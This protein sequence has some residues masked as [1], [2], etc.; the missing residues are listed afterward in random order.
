MRRKVELPA[1]DEIAFEQAPQHPPAPQDTGGLNVGRPY[2]KRR[3]RLA[4][5][6]L[7]LVVVAVGTV[8][9]E[10][11]LEWQA[12]KQGADLRV[13]LVGY[14][15]MDPESCGSEDERVLSVFKWAKDNGAYIHPNVSLGFFS[16]ASLPGAPPDTPDITIRGLRA[17]GD[18][19]QGHALFAV[20]ETL[21]LHVRRLA[22]HHMLGDIYKRVPQLH[23]DIGGLAVLL[24]TEALN[25][26]SHLRPYLC[27]LPEHVPLPVFYSKER[28][29]QTR[30]ALPEAQRAKFDVLVQA[31]RDVIELHYIYLMPV[32]YRDYP[33][34]FKPS[35]YSY[36]RFAWAVSLV[37]SRTWGRRIPAGRKKNFSG[38][39]S[40]FSHIEC[41]L[42]WVSLVMSRTLGCRIPADKMCSGAQNV[43]S[44]SFPSSI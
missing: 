32:L 11:E 26:S 22:T 3:R 35:E 31:R 17:T 8:T 40:L 5:A 27:S 42:F 12:R 21:L 44:F 7:V 30:G 16:L 23:D 25:K 9:M 10:H 36:E 24:I 2:S 18:I 37:M 1:S 43:F 38:Q 28:Y 6:L 19:K 41:I 14:P 34:L 33:R 4:L 13:K 29:A 15:V 20:P 39:K